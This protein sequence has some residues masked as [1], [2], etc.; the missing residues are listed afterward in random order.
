MARRIQTNPR[1]RVETAGQWRSAPRPVDWPAR[2]EAV[3]R[4]D[5]SCRW[6]ISADGTLCGSIEHLEVDHIGDPLDHALT[7][8]RALCRAHHRYRTGQQANQAAAARRIPRRR[9]QE[10]HP[11]LL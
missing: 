3:L 9:P 1:D 2:V 10:P 4:R 5:Q 6:P 8:L 11:G 7:N